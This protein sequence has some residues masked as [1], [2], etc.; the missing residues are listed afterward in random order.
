L[1]VLDVVPGLPL[2]VEL[3]GELPDGCEPLLEVVPV[4]F[5]V[6]DPLVV[7]VDPES[8]GL[9]PVALGSVPPLSAVPR[10]VPALGSELVP[11]V[12]LV[13]AGALVAGMVVEDDAGAVCGALC[14][15]LARVACDAAAAFD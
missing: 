11:L 9:V 12:E 4:P 8:L 1:V 14:L 6:P 10:D 5:V 13:V 7:P 2:V 3:D 15:I